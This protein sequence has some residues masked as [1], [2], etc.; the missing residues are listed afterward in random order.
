LVK[1]DLPNA[2]IAG[3][4]HH[5]CGPAGTEIIQHPLQHALP[6]ATVVCGR[7]D[8]YRLELGSGLFV[9]PREHECHAEWRACLILQHIQI[10][11]VQVRAERFGFVR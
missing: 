2:G 9:V 3:A 11:I 1:R 6:Q 7:V 4:H 10:A 8:R 5:S